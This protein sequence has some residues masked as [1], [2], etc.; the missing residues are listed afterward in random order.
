MDFLMN[1][2]NK[3][4]EKD[5]ITIYNADCI[6]LLKQF[7]DKS[8][9][10][11]LT[12]PP[13]GVNLEYDMYKDTEENWFSLMDSTFPEIIRVSDM[14][15]LPCCR[16]AR[17]PWVYNKYPPDWLICW[18]KG[19]AGYR[20]KIGFNAWEPHIVYGRTKNL[21]MLDFF[22]TRSSPAKGTFGHPCPKP[23]EWAR[24]LIKKSTE[25]EMSILDP[26]MGSGT[27]L[28]VAKQLGRKA[29]GIEISEKYCNIAIDRLER[30]V[31]RKQCNLDN[32]FED[33]D[34]ILH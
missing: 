8:F 18:Y 30:T 27:V 28:V 29:V 5:G 26:F 21:C 2:M 22:K 24:W 13:Y 4:Y 17:L 6:D 23:L 15:I 19:S 31:S 32:F 10:L 3:Y 25:K 16:I 20:S 11:V 12:D 7:N 9:D 14:A 33:D 34:E 1:N